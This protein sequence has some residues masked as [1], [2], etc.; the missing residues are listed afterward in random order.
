MLKLFG[1]HVYFFIV[2][3]CCQKLSFFVR[4]R[5]QGGGGATLRYRVLFCSWFSE[6][7]H[8]GAGWF[9]ST[10]FWTLYISFSCTTLRSFLFFFFFTLC[11]DRLILRL[12]ACIRPCRE[13][14]TWILIVFPE[15]YIRRTCTQLPPTNLYI[16]AWTFRSTYLICQYF[17]LIE[18]CS[19][20]HGGLESGSPN[21]ETHVWFTPGPLLAHTFKIYI[22]VKTLILI[23]KF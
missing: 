3:F 10:C 13:Y 16:Q 9:S 1:S 12:R 2:L 23:L 18:R 5:R 19:E 14:W 7:R 15:G 6:Q 21:L 4:S 11:I 17:S 22:L 20:D 8:V